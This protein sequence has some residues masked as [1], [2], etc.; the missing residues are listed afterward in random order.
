LE[1]I[2]LDGGWV[3]LISYFALAKYFNKGVAFDFT[4][5]VSERFH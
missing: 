3:D 5:S 4:V 2:R 1:E